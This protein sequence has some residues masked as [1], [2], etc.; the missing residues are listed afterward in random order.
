VNTASPKL[1]TESH[2][3][4]PTES[5]QSESSS[6]L[7][8]VVSIFYIDVRGDEERGL[9]YTALH[10]NAGS[11]MDVDASAATYVITGTRTTPKPTDSITISDPADSPTSLP[12]SLA[13]A[14]SKMKGPP[15]HRNKTG[16]PSTITQGPSTFLFTVERG[17]ERT[18]VNRCRLE[19]FTWA[20]CDLTHIGKGWYTHRNPDFNGEWSTYNYTWTTGDRFGFAPVTITAGV[21]KLPVLGEAPEATSDSQDGAAGGGKPGMLKEANIL[22]ALLGVVVGVFVLI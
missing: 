4:E 5:S 11:V 2:T 9:A 12:A 1:E 17:Q 18:V 13:S 19:G 20:T 14:T 8:T 6:A 3:S 7:T 10:R 22:A 21:E 15:S 16:S